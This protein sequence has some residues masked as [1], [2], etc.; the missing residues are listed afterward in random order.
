MNGSG[1]GTCG[2][3]GWTLVMKIGGRKVF[4][5]LCF[6]LVG[7]LGLFFYYSILHCFRS[8]LLKVKD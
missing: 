4:Y 7:A 6:S 2:G 3:G 5:P 1:M 8:N